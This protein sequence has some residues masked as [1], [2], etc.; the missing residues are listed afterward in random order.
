LSSKTFTKEY[1]RPFGDYSACSQLINLH[2]TTH[3]NAYLQFH[4]ISIPAFRPALQHSA[5]LF[6][7][8]NIGRLQKTTAVIPTR[9]GKS[10]KSYRK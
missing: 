7:R 2:H 9:V 6:Q 1:Y 10:L 4:S 5:L 3:T 8:Y